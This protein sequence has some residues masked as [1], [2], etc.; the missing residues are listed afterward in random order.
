MR[1]HSAIDG[2]EHCGVAG[3]E[4][5]QNRGELLEERTTRDDAVLDDF[6]QPGAELTTGKGSQELGVDDH[7]RRL[8]IRADQVLARGVVDADLASDRAIDLR[9]ERR[10]YLD[11][12]YATKERRRGEA[13]DVADD[14]S[15][16]GDNRRRAIRGCADEGIVDASDGWHL[17]EAL[18]VGNEDGLFAGQACEGV[19]VQPPHRRVGDDEAPP[20]DAEGVDERRK[21]CRGATGNLDR[22][23][24]GGCSHLERERIGHVRV[25]RQ[26]RP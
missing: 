5:G 17:L 18:A 16:N 26:N 24:A 25:R 20:R 21:A 23:N 6:V 12:R 2:H 14:T 10:R 4:L 3:E 9:Q 7:S 15:A 19:A 11:D 22:I 8:V 1:Q 13:R